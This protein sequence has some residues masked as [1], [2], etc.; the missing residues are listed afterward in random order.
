MSEREIITAYN[1][2][3]HCYFTISVNVLFTSLI[4][5][6]A[7]GNHLDSEQRLNITFFKQ[8][9]SR[10]IVRL[11]GYRLMNGMYFLFVCLTCSGVAI[12]L[13]AV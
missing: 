8:T 6:A 13:I 1:R 4:F 3:Q 10:K 5:E 7:G 2:P 9:I 11:Q 12:K